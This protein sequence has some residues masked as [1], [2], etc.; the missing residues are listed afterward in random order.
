VIDIP[1]IDDVLI[2]PNPVQDMETLEYTL[3][4]GETLTIELYD[5]SGQ[6]IKVFVSQSKRGKGTHIESLQFDANMIPGIYF[7][8]VSTRNGSLCIK[9]IKQ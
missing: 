3:K 4:Q 2:Y 1:T 8:R 7:L 6:L 9:I 5:I